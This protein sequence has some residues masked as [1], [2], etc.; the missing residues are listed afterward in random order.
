L[1]LLFPQLGAVTGIVRGADGKP[2]PQIRVYAVP[3]GDPN[4]VAA[5]EG[6]TLT[7]TQGRYRLE[8]PAGRYYVASGSVAAPTYF[9]GTSNIASARVITLATGGVV[10]AIDFGSFVPPGRNL[11]SLSATIGTAELSGVIRYPDLSPAAGITVVASTAAF[12]SRSSTDAG[13]RY[14]FQ[15][16][17]ADAI[18]ISAGYSDAATFYPGTPDETAAA[19]VRTTPAT[20]IDTLDFIIPFTV[21]SAVSGRVRATTG[22]SPA[23]TVRLVR[24]PATSASR[25]ITALPARSGSRELRVGND[26]TFEFVDI[27]PGAYTL[28]ALFSGLPPLSRPLTLTKQPVRNIDLLFS[29]THVTG[30]I[31]ME[32]GSPVEAPEFF[33][34]VVAA[35]LGDSRTVTYT[36]FHLASDGTFSNWV[37]SDTYRFYLRVM[38]EE[39]EIA[40]MTAGSID[41]L[42]NSMKAL[43]DAPLNVDIRIRRKSGS[44]ETAGERVA[45]SVLDSISALP[46]AAA[47]IRLCCL[48]SGPV[49]RLSAPI[50]ADGSFEFANVP[51]GKY[52]PRLQV[53]SPWQTDLY[54]VEQ[55]VEVRNSQPNEWRLLSAPEFR[56]LRVRLDVEGPALPTEPLPTVVFTS[57]SGRVRIPAQRDVNATG[58]TFRALVPSGDQYAI[59]VGNL[60]GDYTVRSRPEP[61]EVPFVAARP[62][63]PPVVRITIGNLR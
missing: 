39:Y 55:S 28:Q 10:D 2:A 53:R 42:K 16:L 54:L 60:P 45:G 36:T 4:A 6:Q 20:K 25:A 29:I 7:D 23:F 1:G 46:A 11:L 51:P 34:E 62:G 8:L 63:T 15:G 50:R 47:R 3:A 44:R 30:R 38:P 27:M 21:G 12:S 56:E 22:G 13:G 41:L 35:T 43:S 5:I 40:S 61:V 18:V 17:P 26:G 37:A 49:E 19:P 33:E 14:R 48:S 9:P 58:W 59:S 32:D 24:D 31:F 57:N 52:S